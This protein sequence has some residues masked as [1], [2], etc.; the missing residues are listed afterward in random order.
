LEIE[1]SDHLDGSMLTHKSS[2]QTAWR[3]GPSRKDSRPVSVMPSLPPRVK[4][5]RPAREF[6]CDS[7]DILVACDNWIVD[8]EE[9]MLACANHLY[10]T[11]EWR[12]QN[13]FD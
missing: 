8:V 6:S 3:P 2:R 11:S 1:N 12:N 5:P 7:G 4:L 9:S 13:Q 10:R